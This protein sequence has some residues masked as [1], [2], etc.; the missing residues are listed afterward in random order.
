MT[1][2]VGCRREVDWFSGHS[3]QRIF[4]ISFSSSL[5]KELRSVW[6]LWFPQIVGSHSAW[7]SVLVAGVRQTGLVGI[8]T[9]ESF[10]FRFSLLS[11]KS[12]G[13]HGLCGL[14]KLCGSHSAYGSQCW[15]SEWDRVVWVAFLLENHSNSYPSLL[16]ELEEW[17][18]SHL[19]ND[20]RRC[21]VQHLGQDL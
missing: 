16:K 6:P 11:L 13:L 3:Y 12:C 21:I 8:L 9:R 5:I 10:P 19:V 20:G 18:A 17:L 2:S 15:F 14:P 4:L 1:V 7:Q